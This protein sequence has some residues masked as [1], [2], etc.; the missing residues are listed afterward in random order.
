MFPHVDAEDGGCAVNQRVFA[1]R[2]LGDGELAVLD[3][4]PGPAGAELG[5]AGGDEVG[6]ELVVAAEI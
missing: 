1:V 2:G 3:R 5:G 4:E 6:L